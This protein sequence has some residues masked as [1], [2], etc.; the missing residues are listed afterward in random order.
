MNTLVDDTGEN[1][2]GE[3]PP[4]LTQWLH[5][6][7]DKDPAYSVTET[8][9]D[10]QSR[11]TRE[12]LAVRS[13]SKLVLEDE[14][15]KWDTIR[16]VAGSFGKLSDDLEKLSQNFLFQKDME[17]LGRKDAPSKIFEYTKLVSERIEESNI[18][19]D[20][21]AAVLGDL[22]TSLLRHPLIVLQERIGEIGVSA[23]HKK[24][25]ALENAYKSFENYRVKFFS[26]F[27]QVLGFSN[28]PFAM[29][30]SDPFEKE[31]AE[32]LLN[33]LKV[34]ALPEGMMRKYAEKKE[35]KHFEK[36]YN[37]FMK[38]ELS[39][40]KEELEEEIKL[41]RAELEERSIRIKNMTSDPKM[42]EALKKEYE[43]WKQITPEKR[44]KQLLRMRAFEL[45]KKSAGE[46]R[47]TPEFMYK[48]YTQAKTLPQQVLPASTAATT[49]SSSGETSRESAST[50]PS[51]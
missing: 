11:P 10:E 51:A 6:N 29:A 39:V 13:L 41:K 8:S 36:D 31:M 7:P 33:A 37:L 43:Y 23:I 35:S 2:P 38:I 46:K 47:L 12:M 40:H 48:L 34:P 18:F 1:K 24:P 20:E 14:S 27:S 22:I 19:L 17:D 26:E 44:Y 42:T 16:E 25:E 5:G 15:K 50:T 21:K 3:E 45:L 4:Y 49:E 30:D 28:D 32:N 9:A